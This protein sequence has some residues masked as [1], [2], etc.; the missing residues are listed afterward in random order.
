LF[1]SIARLTE[2]SALNQRSPPGC[3]LCSGDV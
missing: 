2:L 1:L 3:E